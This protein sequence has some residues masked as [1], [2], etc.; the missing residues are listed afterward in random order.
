M[1]QSLLFALMRQKYKQLVKIPNIW[2][3]FVVF[4]NNSPE[5]VNQVNSNSD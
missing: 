4:S 3:V 2:A 1:Y 5:Y